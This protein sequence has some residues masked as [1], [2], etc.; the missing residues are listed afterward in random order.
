MSC[1]DLIESVQRRL[2]F[3]R[4]MNLALCALLPAALSAA[5]WLCFSRNL[6]PSGL[7]LGAV[8]LVTVLALALTEALRPLLRRASPEEAARAVDRATG[9]KERFLTVATEPEGSPAVRLV[10][11]QAAA[12]IETFDMRTAVPLRLER[13]SRISLFVS[14]LIA[15]TVLAVLYWPRP[16]A[17]VPPPV[18]PSD[19]V[20]QERADEIRDLLDRSP[21]LPQPARE[22]LEK[23]SQALDQ[24]GLK[25]EETAAM[26]E[27]ATET[28]AALDSLEEQNKPPKDTV[29]SNTSDLTEPPGRDNGRQGKPQ[30]ISAS[31]DRS[32]PNTPDHQQSEESKEQRSPSEPA[33]ARSNPKEE[34]PAESKQSGDRESPPPSESEKQSAGEK[35]PKGA[36]QQPSTQSQKDQAKNEQSGKDQQQAAKQAEK[37]SAEGSKKDGSKG[38]GAQKSPE[39]GAKQQSQDGE[40]SGSKEARQSEKKQTTEDDPQKDMTGVG[41]GNG[42]GRSGSKK[43]Q[44]GETQSGSDDSGAKDGDPKNEAKQ[45]GSSGGDKASKGKEQ[46]K[47]NGQQADSSNDKAGKQSSGGESGGPAAALQQKLQQIRREMEGRK[48]QQNGPDG[49]QGEKQQDQKQQGSGAKGEGQKGERKQQKPGDSQQQSGGDQQKQA[50]DQKQPGQKQGPGDEKQNKPDGKT[51]EEKQSGGEKSPKSQEQKQGGQQ[52]DSQQRQSPEAKGGDPKKQDGEKSAQKEQ[53]QDSAGGKQGANPE[54]K[55]SGDPANHAKQPQEPQPAATPNGGEPKGGAQGNAKG[56]TEGRPQEDGK[57]DSERALPS[58]VRSQRPEGHPE[59]GDAGK[60]LGPFGGGDEG[61]LQVKDQQ[62]T[63][64]FIPPEEKLV[65]RSLGESDGKRYRNSGESKAKTELGAAD[66]IKP[67]P[68]TA[69]QSQ[70]IPVEYQGILR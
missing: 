44:K 70:P 32:T 45:A 22:S 4:W 39:N 40:K 17:A 60:K 34:P 41:E 21:E 58:Q 20:A 13:P 48:P 29:S 64:V 53:P 16:P 68:D 49:K 27:E 31:N 15:G 30:D 56:A 63:K 1:R 43:E 52:A 3:I 38:D 2:R 6:I 54:T 28:L 19:A 61:D 37:E 5:A 18:I 66:F 33:N 51:P 25:D 9:A 26:L 12:F 8:A 46:G 69:G 7:Q 67:P 50:A 24:H 57:Q 10:E 36:D 42:K 11:S 47:G 65:V 55:N 59:P 35:Q 23:L 62:T 14:P